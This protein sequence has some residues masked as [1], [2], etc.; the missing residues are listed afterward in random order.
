MRRKVPC[1]PRIPNAREHSPAGFE[2]TVRAG[3]SLARLWRS[4][5]K[6]REAYDLLFP[7]YSWFTEGFSWIRMKEAK[8]LLDELR[9]ELRIS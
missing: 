5:G 4:Q 2:P 9:L 8:T 3:T 7:V 6:S 1:L